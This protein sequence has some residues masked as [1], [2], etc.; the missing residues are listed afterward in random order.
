M[1]QLLLVYHQPLF[2]RAFGEAIAKKSDGV[3]INFVTD[4]KTALKHLVLRPCDMILT[5]TRLPVVDGLQ[6]LLRVQQRF[7]YVA[8]AV[9][10]T[11]VDENERKQAA[12][13]GVVL[14]FEKPASP[15]DYDAAAERVIQLLRSSS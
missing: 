7:P 6:L 12:E 14:Y 1:K 10:A 5:D 4:A 2:C 11:H 15:P 9:M 8:R 3:T 13:Y